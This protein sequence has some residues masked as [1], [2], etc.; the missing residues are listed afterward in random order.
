MTWQPDRCWRPSDIFR[1]SGV[2]GVNISGFALWLFQMLNSLAQS[3]HPHFVPRTLLLWSFC[4]W[5]FTTNDA[6][7]HAS[8][9][10]VDTTN[11]WRRVPNVLS[12]VVTSTQVYFISNNEIHLRQSNIFWIPPKLLRAKDGE[13]PPPPFSISLSSAFAFGNS[14]ELTFVLKTHLDRWSVS[15]NDTFR[16]VYYM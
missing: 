10:D 2:R 7:F 8:V 3:S 6:I 14:Y 16:R 5:N 13:D 12:G 1:M 9:K 4:L 15:V 11:A